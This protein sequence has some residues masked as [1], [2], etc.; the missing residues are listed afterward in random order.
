MSFNVDLEVNG[1][2]YIVGC[3]LV[4][5]AVTSLNDILG[6]ACPDL[7]AFRDILQGQ[8]EKVLQREMKSF[9]AEHG[10]VPESLRSIIKT[11]HPRDMQ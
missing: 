1:F 5:S 9:N 8:A 10:Q 6:D 3:G 7:K 11:A 4:G 2:D